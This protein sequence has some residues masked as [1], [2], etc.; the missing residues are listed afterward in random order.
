MT[1]IAII[2]AM[3]GELTPLVRGWRRETRN[4]VKL[5]RRSHG[6]S[7]WAAAC[8]GAGAGA[9]TRAFSEIERAGAADLV[10]STGWAG[11]L[12]EEFAVGRAYGVSEVVDA[13]SGER[14][15]AGGPSGGCRLVTGRGFADLPEKRHLGAAFGAALVD[16]EAAAVA[17]LAQRRGIPFLC[18]KGVSDGLND[19][20]PDFSAYI[21]TDGQFAWARFVLFAV[22]RPWL[23]PAL[24]RTGSS[25]RKAA[26]GIRDRL[27]E[28]LDTRDTVA[29]R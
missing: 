1:R 11:A 13:N 18:V 3:E 19:R 14:F 8:A 28:I 29:N 5:W 26:L 27:L 25:C 12:R 16:M 24:A 20:L 4:G 21:S 23:W 17:R 22:P 7:E 10:V 15:R 6:A 2:A 9:A